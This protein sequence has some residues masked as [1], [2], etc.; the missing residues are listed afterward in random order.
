[1]NAPAFFI[2]SQKS[3]QAFESLKNVGA[4]ILS[5]RYASL[6]KND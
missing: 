5:G 4:L 3:N 2:E 6:L 1:M